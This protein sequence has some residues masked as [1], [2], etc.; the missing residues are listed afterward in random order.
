MFRPTRFTALLNRNALFYTAWMFA[1]NVAR[2]VRPS[3][4][5]HGASQGSTPMWTESVRARQLQKGVSWPRPGLH[6][7]FAA[8]CFAVAL[9]AEASHG[10]P[11]QSAQEAKV[12]AATE[13]A[14]DE[15]CAECHQKQAATYARTPHALDSSLPT[16]KTILGDFTPGKAVLRTSNPNL[17]FGMIAAPDGFYQSAINL[18][19]PQHSTPELKRFDIVIGSGRHGQTY[20]HWEGNELFELPVSYWTYTHQWASSPGYPEGEVHWDRPVGPRC[21]ECHASYFTTQGPPP[22]RYVKDSVVLGIGC[23][24]C[25]GPGALHVTREHS[26]NSPKAGSSDQAIVN[27]ARLAQDRQIGLCALCHA[28]GGRPIRPS[29]T[30]EVGENLSEYLKITPPPSD[31][32]VDVHGNQVGGLEQSKCFSSG[33]LT[34]STCHNVHETQENTAAYSRHCLECHNVNACPRYRNMGETIRGRCIDCHMPLGKSS[35]I[36]TANAGQEMRATMRA[37]RI[38]IYPNAKLESRNAHSAAKGR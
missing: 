11:A 24:R 15:A 4:Q 8:I 18:A 25:H 13:Y 23:E 9:Q 7:L 35:A 28:G 32:P 30:Y 10:T 29:M 38:A 1:Q 14:G 3:L 5:W 36:K 19:D 33:K 22:N 37:H 26:A 20:L 17:I 16:A 6:A 12:P 2:R 21:L 31:A 27:P 34:C